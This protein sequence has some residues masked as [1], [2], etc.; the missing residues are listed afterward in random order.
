MSLKYEI[1][2]TGCTCR[3]RV[4]GLE[5]ST[6]CCTHTHTIIGRRSTRFRFRWNRNVVWRCRNEFSRW[7][8]FWQSMEG[9]FAIWSTCI[10]KYETACMA[11]LGA[12][13]C[14]L[15]SNHFKF[16]M[17][18]NTVWCVF[19]YILIMISNCNFHPKLCVQH[20]G[21]SLNSFQY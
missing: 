17:D 6:I 8:V 10:F 7:H 11:Q 12:G 18:Q 3:Q 15:L 9:S 19:Y 5:C 20:V 13:S 4:W 16:L 2:W 1:R 14:T 21:T